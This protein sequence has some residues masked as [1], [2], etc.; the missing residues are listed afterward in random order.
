MSMAPVV[1]NCCARLLGYEWCWPCV[2]LAGL[3]G[4][5][6]RQ[7]VSTQVHLSLSQCGVLVTGVPVASD[8]TE[9]KVVW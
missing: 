1:A 5:P 9:A 6:V 4:P 2:W 8:A 7:L 3:A